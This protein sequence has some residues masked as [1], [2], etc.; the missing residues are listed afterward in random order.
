[1]TKRRYSKEF[2][3]YLSKQS[4]NRRTDTSTIV[5]TYTVSD[6]E[7]IA[8]HAKNPKKPPKKPSFKD[9]VSIDWSKNGY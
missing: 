9:N 7:R 4:N 6:W 5:N 3:D 2:E 8:A 1:M